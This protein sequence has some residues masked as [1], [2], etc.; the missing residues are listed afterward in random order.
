VLGDKANKQ[1][2]DRTN[3][4]TNATINERVLV[5]VDVLRTVSFRGKFKSATLHYASLL[6]R[7]FIFSCSLLV[8]FLP[9]S[10][11]PTTKHISSATTCA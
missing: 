4:L 1:T 10:H 9:N 8:S 5:S 6:W 2:N 7:H 11:V 3:E